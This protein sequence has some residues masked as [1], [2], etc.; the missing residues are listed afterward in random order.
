MVVRK[1]TNK[2]LK[3]RSPTTRNEFKM[4]EFCPAHFP[5]EKKK[6]KMKL[7]LSTRDV[8]IL[9]IQVPANF[10]RF[11]SV[12]GREISPGALGVPFSSLSPAT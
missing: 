9:L 2:L 12:S 8:G 6:R 10:S 7:Q 4:D 11:P 1:E 3:T 5:K